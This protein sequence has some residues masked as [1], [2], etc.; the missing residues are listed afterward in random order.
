MK[1]INLAKKTRYF[2]KLDDMDFNAIMN[3][4][5]CRIVEYKKGQ[6]IV[7]I[8]D[9]A[10][11]AYLF[12]TGSARSVSYDTEGNVFLNLDYEK[13]SIFGLSEI[14]SQK[15]KFNKH[16]YA[17]EDSTVLLMSRFRLMSPS[18]NRCMRHIILMKECLLEL[19]R[20]NNELYTNKNILTLKTTRDKVLTYLKEYSKKKRSKEINIPYDRQELALYLGVERSA[21]SSELSKL[22][23]E[24]YIDFSKNHFKILKKLD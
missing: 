21:L 5:S 11:Y 7:N 17:L 13:E 3:C 9:E 4:L 6:T 1:N 15:S 22:K 24:G 2:K 10:D 23:K 19:S 12:L 14:A 18:L 20:Q 16:L 8:S